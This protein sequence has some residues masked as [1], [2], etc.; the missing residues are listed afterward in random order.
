[1]SSKKPVQ[2]TL[3]HAKWCGHCVNFMPTWETMK[4]NP[5]NTKKIDFV[6]VED[7]EINQMSAGSRPKIE[8]FPTIKVSIKGK[9]YDYNGKRNESDIFKF[10]INKIKGVNT[11]ESTTDA[12]TITPMS[13]DIQKGGLN[14]I[15]TETMNDMARNSVNNLSTPMEGGLNRIYTE[16][17]NDM[18]RN[19]V[20]NLSTPMEGGQNSI[21]S[22]LSAQTQTDNNVYSAPSTATAANNTNIKYAPHVNMK[23]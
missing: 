18:A 15:Y 2:I 17:M 7:S 22:P 16:T 8:G 6:S 12:H 4:S 5:K 13:D 19:S 10:I 14:N 9:T 23:F 11:T 20:N 1:M 21:F 3:Y